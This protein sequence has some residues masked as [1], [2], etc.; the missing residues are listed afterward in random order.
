MK[1]KRK[2]SEIQIFISFPLHVYLD[3]FLIPL[4]FLF[5][6]RRE[7]KARAYLDLLS[8]LPSQDDQECWDYY[9]TT[10]TA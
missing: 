6:E 5:S 4:P 7:L 9:S 10:A 1:E 2:R 8:P 3:G